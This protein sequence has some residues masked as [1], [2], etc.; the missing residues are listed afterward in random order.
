MHWCTHGTGTCVVIGTDCADVATME[1]QLLE[2]KTVEQLK[3]LLKLNLQ[4]ASGNKNDL[5]HRVAE[6]VVCGLLWCMLLYRE[7]PTFLT[8]TAVCMHALEGL[9]CHASPLRA[10]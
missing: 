6:A 1:Q 2:T 9:A 5:A 7:A 10:R 3:S 8:C 4:V